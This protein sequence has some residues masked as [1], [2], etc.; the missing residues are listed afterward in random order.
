MRIEAL[1]VLENSLTERK[2]VNGLCIMK[3]EI[4]N[5]NEFIM[6]ELKIDYGFSI[7]KI[8]SQKK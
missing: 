2:M 5:L 1:K 7:M 3:I 8:E 4:K 6:I